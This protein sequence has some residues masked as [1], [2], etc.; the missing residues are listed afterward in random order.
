MDGTEE[1]VKKKGIKIVHLTTHD[2]QGFYSKLGYVNS[3]PVVVYGGI[4]PSLQKVLCSRIVLYGHLKPMSS[5]SEM[6]C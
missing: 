3:E 6:M 5:T 1:F 2:Q 4:S